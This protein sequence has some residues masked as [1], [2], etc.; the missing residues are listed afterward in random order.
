MT[1]SSSPGISLKMEGLS[2]IAGAELPCVVVNVQRGGPGLGDIQPAQGDYFQATKGGGHGDYR[3][4]VLAP[5]SVQEFADMASEAFDFTQPIHA[6]TVIYLKWTSLPQDVPAVPAENPSMNLG[7]ILAII[8]GGSGMSFSDVTSSDWFFE[9]VAAAYQLGLMNG[10]STYEFAPKAPLSR[11]MVAAM[12]YRM[13]GSPAAYYGGRQFTDGADGKWY[14][15]VIRWA[16]QM[17]IVTGFQDGSFRPNENVTRVQLAAMLFR[18]AQYQSRDIQGRGDLNSYQDSSSVQ[19]WAKEA[20]QWA[21]AKGLISGK[22]GARLDPSGSAT[23]A[24]AAAVLV[25]F[26]RQS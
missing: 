12:L 5:S 16:S 2:Y 6:D 9:D 22:S 7:L 20:I 15:S 25:R 18:F 23:R 3:L 4:I 1:S 24:E 19:A 17:G 10:V 21:V 11:A 14:S 13:A 26:L 8:N